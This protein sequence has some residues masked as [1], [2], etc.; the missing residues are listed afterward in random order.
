MDTNII[1][2][3]K[4]S[5]TLVGIG[6]DFSK[7]NSFSEIPKYWDEFMSSDRP[8]IKG[9]FGICIDKETDLRYFIAD[10]YYPWISM[11]PNLEPVTFEAGLWA[12]FSADG[13]LPDS[14]QEVTTY[15]WKEWIPGNKE[16]ELR[17]DYNI[18]FYPHD[19]MDLEYTHSEIWL[20]VKKR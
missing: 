17:A 1:I 11:L 20:P 14:L 12:M 6:R 15:V 4:P 19:V 10:I 5:F 18:E 2:E 13:P 16:Y 8:P 3:E 7:E 9:R